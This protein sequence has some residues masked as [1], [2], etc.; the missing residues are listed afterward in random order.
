MT[1]QPPQAVA[2]DVMD[3]VVRDP[4][5]EAL[6]AAT[7]VPVRE[8]FRTRSPESYPR[9]ERGEITEAEYWDVYRDAG[10]DLDVEVFHRVR[11]A[12]YRWLEGMAGLLDDLAGVVPRVA[13]TN[14][15]PWIVELAEGMLAG[16]FEAIVAS[17]HLGARKPE[18]AFF[19]G[20][21]ATIERPAGAVV[22]VD[23]RE[24]N[25]EAAAAYGL[26]AHQFTEVVDLRRR[27]RA[28]GLPV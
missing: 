7:G 9:F 2:F 1:D 11:R 15:P 16:R 24:V 21:L 6:E 20:L 18:P 17:C 14:Y 27:L 25:V 5:R 3:T 13:A 22:F 4:Y 28:E 8:L 23:D 12:G 19:A 26:R 10:L